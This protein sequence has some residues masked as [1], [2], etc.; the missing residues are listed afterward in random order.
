MNSRHGP[1]SQEIPIRQEIPITTS[2]SP[3]PLQFPCAPQANTT[4]PTAHSLFFLDPR[5]IAI[6]HR[7]HVNMSGGQI[8]EE[9]REEGEE[10]EREE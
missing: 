3:H 7:L 9:E 1:F 2:P 10:E 4:I 6:P 5:F 8:E